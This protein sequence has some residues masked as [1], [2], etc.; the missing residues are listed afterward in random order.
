MLSIYPAIFYKEETG[1]YSVCFPDFDVAT[2]GDDLNDAMNMAIECLAAQIIWTQKD[3][4]VLPPPSSMESID[5]IAYSRSLGTEP[6]SNGFASLIS[7]DAEEYAKLHFN[8]SVRKN[9]TIPQ[10]L[11]DK[12]LAQGINFSQVLQEALLEKVGGQ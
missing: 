6:P 2:C 4:E 8:K 5:P 12:A 7:V 9:L 10:W 1:R 3:G 11:N